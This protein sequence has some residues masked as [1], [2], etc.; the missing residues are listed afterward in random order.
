[1]LLTQVK[2]IEYTLVFPTYSYDPLVVNATYAHRPSTW[3]RVST[4]HG[5]TLLSLAFNYGV[6]SLVTLTFGTERMRVELRD[7]PL[8]CVTSPR[9]EGERLEMVLYPLMRDFKV[10]NELKHA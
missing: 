10:K 3:A 8:G 1:M 4:R 2:L 5:Q 7:E 9:T 6:L